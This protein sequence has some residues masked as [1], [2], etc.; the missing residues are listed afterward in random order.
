MLA[1][2]DQPFTRTIGE[3]LQ[4]MTVFRLAGDASHALA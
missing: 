2:W 1:P 3:D 4:R